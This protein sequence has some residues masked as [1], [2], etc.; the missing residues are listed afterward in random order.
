MSA[1]RDALDALADALE[2]ALAGAG[3]SRKATPAEEPEEAEAPAPARGKSKKKAA[4]TMEEVREAMIALNSEHG[5]PAVIDVLS[6]FGVTKLGDLPEEH[7]AEAKGLAEE[8]EPEAAEPEEEEDP[9]GDNDADEDVDEPEEEE[10]E[11]EPPKRKRN[12]K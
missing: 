1:I 4:V 12:R 3:K 9:L 5:K 11:P 2:A 6:R 10:E 7:F 8:Y